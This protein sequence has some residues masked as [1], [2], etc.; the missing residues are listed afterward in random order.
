MLPPPAGC[1]FTRTAT[2]GAG[3]SAVADGGECDAWLASSCR[4]RPPRFLRNWSNFASREAFSAR[5]LSYASRCIRARR[6]RVARRRC[7]S[8]SVSPPPRACASRASLAARSAPSRRCCSRRACA[9]RCCR[10]S[11]RCFVSS[12]NLVS[13]PR[14]RS[15]ARS[16]SSS[17]RFCAI[18]RCRCSSLRRASARWR[19][20][21][22][23]G[24]SPQQ[25]R[26]VVRTAY[27]S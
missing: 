26:G 15:F 14:W 27:L 2:S 4:H 25:G 11:T 12:W 6:S 17:L 13:A 1:T 3:E 22:R 20:R 16:R 8:A 24:P 10:A 7:T 19:A 9:S 23:L 5:S 18:S 21:G